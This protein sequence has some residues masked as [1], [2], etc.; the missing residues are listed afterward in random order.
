[1]KTIVALS[2]LAFS[3]ANLNVADM[4]ESEFQRDLHSCCEWVC[5]S[6]SYSYRS[7][8]MMSGSG[9]KKSGSGSKKS[10]SGSYGSYYGSGYYRRTEE[11]EKEEAVDEPNDRVVGQGLLSHAISA[12]ARAD[13]RMLLGL[14]FVRSC[15]WPAQLAWSRLP[16]LPHNGIA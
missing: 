2:I 10:G 5:P 6:D 13:L 16:M 14:L 9:S 12:H 8:G 7:K 15:T 4:L 11:H 3:A 1:M